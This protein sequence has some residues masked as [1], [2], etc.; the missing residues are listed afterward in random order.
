MFHVVTLFARALQVPKNCIVDLS[1][2]EGR[3]KWLSEESGDPWELDNALF[4]ARSYV[5]KDREVVLLTVP[6]RMDVEKLG[7]ADA[8]DSLSS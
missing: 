2:M 4:P 1:T 5:A 6:P 8:L 7:P 3:K